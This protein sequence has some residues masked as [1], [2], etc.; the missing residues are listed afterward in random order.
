MAAIVPAL[1]PTLTGF[2]PP[3][4]KPGRD[5]DKDNRGNDKDNRGYSVQDE[6]EN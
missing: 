1:L 4:E 5:H 3:V 2:V 6:E